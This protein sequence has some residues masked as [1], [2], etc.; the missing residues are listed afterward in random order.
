MK[1]IMLASVLMWGGVTFAQEV[2]QIQTV[3]KIDTDSFIEEAFLPFKDM[4]IFHDK[5]R[6]KYNGIDIIYSAF[7][8]YNAIIGYHF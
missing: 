4:K 2:P 8:Q 3:Q 1:K 7:K 6:F 5:K